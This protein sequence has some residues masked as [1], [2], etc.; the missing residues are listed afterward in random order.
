MTCSTALANEPPASYFHIDEFDFVPC[1]SLTTVI[2]SAL[3]HACDEVKWS[4]L[5]K[6]GKVESGFI[7]KICK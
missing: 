4:S 2:C 6:C 3:G 5:G 7:Y 1:C